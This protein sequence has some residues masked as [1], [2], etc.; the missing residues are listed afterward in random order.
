MKLSEFPYQRPD[1]IKIIAQVR[2]LKQQLQTAKSTNQAISVVEAL[3]KL[4]AHVWHLQGLAKMRHDIDTTNSSLLEEVQYIDQQFPTYDNEATELKRIILASNY[5]EVL[6]E[7]YGD[8]LINI[9]TTHVVSSS[10]DTVQE[11]EDEA[12]LMSK[13]GQ[14]IANIVVDFEG[15]TVPI[16]T[17][18]GKMLHQ[19]R[20]IRIKAK[21]VF[22]DYYLTN[23]EKYATIFEKLVQIRHQKATKMG[24]KN[25]IP[26]AYALLGRS[27]YSQKEVEQFRNHIQKYFAPIGRELFE[28]Q[29][30]R[31]E[32][33]ELDHYDIS[34]SFKSGNPQLVDKTVEGLLEKA[35]QMYQEIS[36]DMNTFF[37]YMLTNERFDLVARPAKYPGAYSGPIIADQGSFILANFNGTAY[38]VLILTH[39][40][41]HAFQA[42]TSKKVGQDCFYYLFPSA[43]MSEVH[44]TTME[45]FTLPWQELFFGA[46]ADKYRFDK[47]TDMV[48]AQLHFCIGD[49]FQQ[50]I[51]E[52]PDLGANAWSEK[53][54]EIS[55]K[56][57]S[58]LSEAYLNNHPYFVNGKNW[59]EVAHYFNN[60]FYF[61]DYGLA[62]ICALQLWQRSQ[63]DFE[64]AWND[65]LK[66][67]KVGG[68]LSYFEFLELANLQSPFEEE[69]IANMASFVKAW[70]DG[71]DDTQF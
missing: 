20:A 49:E 46:D 7:K 44:S 51:Y 61:I 55:K 14:Q 57:R 41:G 39:E 12:E 52:H 2:Q 29:K 19:D 9:L 23:F 42:Y 40:I 11:G 43:D 18:Y 33:K 3:M 50:Y 69:T 5:R 26:L 31:L 71:I 15:E 62:G 17:L 48:F 56:Y 65:Y 53:Y 60:P 13:Y 54:Y 28:R 37:Q 30:K 34:L 64:G 59:I 66:L 45:L 16:Y 27:D 6:V 36:P 47:I 24:Y 8:R 67:C 35:Q 1:F 58:Y 22:A 10:K 68:S 38:D 4:D 70:L 63:T 25:L 32:V 21:D